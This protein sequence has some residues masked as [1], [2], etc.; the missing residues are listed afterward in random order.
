M[1]K[2]LPPPPPPTPPPRPPPPAPLQPPP[3]PAPW[4]PLNVM[5]APR[6]QGAEQAP[7]PPLPPRMQPQPPPLVLGGGAGLGVAPGA[8]EMTPEAAL[9]WLAVEL[10]RQQHLQQQ[11]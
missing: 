9:A 10:V 6:A 4:I 5:F 11:A 2:E 8:A 7:D 1:L 3:P